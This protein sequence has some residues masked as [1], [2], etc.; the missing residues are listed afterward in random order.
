MVGHSTSE[1]YVL[2][3]W[4]FP[5]PNM[6]SVPAKDRPVM[7]TET[8]N[9]IKNYEEGHPVALEIAEGLQPCYYPSYVMDWARWHLVRV[10][11]FAV[12]SQIADTVED[13]EWLVAHGKRTGTLNT[14]G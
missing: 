2:N 1:W 13:M 4:P 8:K 11:R 9:F 7:I 12:P 14:D 5:L 6:P 3:S 10:Q